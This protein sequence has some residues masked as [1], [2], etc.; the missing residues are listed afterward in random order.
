MELA[1]YD[2]NSHE[3]D[4]QESELLF[5]LYYACIICL[6]PNFWRDGVV[7]VC[8]LEGVITGSVYCNL[9]EL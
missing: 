5:F 2:L 1:T 8:V 6:G 3:R 4:G 7:I 9:S